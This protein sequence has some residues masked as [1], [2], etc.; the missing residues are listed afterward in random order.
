[1]TL[2]LLLMACL[3]EDLQLLQVQ[4]SGEVLPPD[5]GPQAG[6]VTLVFHH[7]WVGEGELEH[8]LGPIDSL[9]LD[10]PGPF[11]AELLYPVEAGEGLVLYA[12][13]DADRDGALCAPDSAPEASGLVEV[14]GFPAYAVEADVPLSEGCS[15]AEVLF[16]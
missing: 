5:T 8:P 3:S 4:V 1:M 15:G 12:W 13:L 10:G 2:L 9:T 6:A 11:E 7:A 14:E 16:P